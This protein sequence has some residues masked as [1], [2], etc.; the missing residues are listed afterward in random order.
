MNMSRE[1]I[2]ALVA[3]AVLLACA[4]GAHAMI[5]GVTGPAF[6]LTATSGNISTPDGNSIFIWGFA[7][8]SGSVQYPG[9]TMIVTEGD[10]VSVTLT[11]AL[12]DPVSIVFPG[13]MGVAAAQAAA[14]TAPGLIALEA[15]PG[16]AVTYTFVATHPGTYLYQSGTRPELQIEMG[17]F[18]ALIVRPMDA[19]PPKGAEKQ[20]MEFLAYNTMDSMYNVE[21]LFLLSAIDPEIHYLVETGRIAEVDSSSSVA[22][23][24]FINGRCAPDTM[25]E[26]FATWLPTQ[27]YNCMPMMHAGERLLM[28]VATASRGFHPFHF[29]GNHASTIARDGRVLSTPSG[30]DADLAVL[31]FTILAIPGKTEDAIYTW[32]GEKLGWDVYGHEHD[33]DEPPT[34]NFPGP[35]DI[36]H[37][38]NGVLDTVPLEPHEYEPDHGKPLPTVLPE[39]QSMT[40]G[41]M[42]S[43][44]PYL[45]VLGSLPPGQGGMNPSAGFMHMWHSH[46]EKELLNGDIFPGGMMTMVLIDAPS[47]THHMP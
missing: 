38:G 8:G 10:T 3:T 29:H 14:P 9:P 16:G 33:R 23:Y 6:N 11:N 12:A 2:Q 25:A 22:M 21:F 28:R 27:P 45:G 18:G 20:P 30:T 41:G 44:S 26:P 17:L 24:Y 7:N 13:Q 31:Q 43:G 19:M 37:N 15:G 36:D 32:T 34:G 39:L 42:Y 35:E 5:H 1:R 4:G 47:V 46:S 40:F